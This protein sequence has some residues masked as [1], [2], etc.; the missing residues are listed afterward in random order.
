M[1]GVG[2]GEESESGKDSFRAPAMAGAWWTL[3]GIW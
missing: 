2:D 1:N 3:M